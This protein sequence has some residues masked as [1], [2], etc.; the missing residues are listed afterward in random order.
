MK[1]LVILLLLSVFS[2]NKKT[3][4]T[5]IEVQ[6]TDTLQFKPAHTTSETTSANLNPETEIE[7]DLLGNS[8]KASLKQI[9]EQVGNPVEDGTPAEYIIVFNESAIPPLNI[10][11][12][13]AKLINEGDLNNDGNEELS[14]YQ[15]PMNGCTYTLT[16]YTFKNGEWKQLIPPFLIPT[17]CEE[18]PLDEIKKR[19]FQENNK[20]YIY[21]T[22]MNDENFKLIKTEV[23]PL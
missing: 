10:G 11:C 15:E 22:D 12:C 21:K 1:K 8:T 13:A 5:K 14:V 6:Q 7:I 16:T 2:C 4:E 17:A 20:I 3:P 18:I 9:K 19:I 23:K